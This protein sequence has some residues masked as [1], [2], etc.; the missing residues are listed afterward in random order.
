MQK[1][2]FKFY[3]P[4]DHRCHP[5]RVADPVSVAVASPLSRLVSALTPLVVGV[6]FCFYLP[7]VKRGN[8]TDF[9]EW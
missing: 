6:A 8:R 1:P 3:S 4:P 5:E 2:H 9:N 7:L